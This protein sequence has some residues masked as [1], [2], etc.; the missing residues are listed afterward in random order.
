[1]EISRYFQVS[2]HTLTALVGHWVISCQFC[3]CMESELWDGFCCA[4]T[5]GERRA[6]LPL[7]ITEICGKMSIIWLERGWDGLSV[8]KAL[9]VQACRSEVVLQPSCKKPGVDACTSN[10]TAVEWTQDGSH[11]LGMWTVWVLLAGQPRQLSKPKP[12]RETLSEVDL[13]PPQ[14]RVDVYT[15]GCL[16]PNTKNTI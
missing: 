14:A 5:H 13:W 11:W 15:H 4:N 7:H 10:P 9:V 1:M 8:G 12:L 16:S 6:L 2:A 3:V